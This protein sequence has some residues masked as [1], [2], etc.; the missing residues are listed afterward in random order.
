MWRER[1]ESWVVALGRV[2]QLS[3][4]EKVIKGSPTIATPSSCIRRI[5]CAIQLIPTTSTYKSRLAL[6]SALAVTKGTAVSLVTYMSTDTTPHSLRGLAHKIK[7]SHRANG[8]QEFYSWQ[9]F[10]L[11]K[12]IMDN[13]RWIKET[14]QRGRARG[15]ECIISPCGTVPLSMKDASEFAVNERCDSVVVGCRSSNSHFSIALLSTS[16]AA[17]AERLIV[18]LCVGSSDILVS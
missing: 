8:N 2:T 13:S 3:R 15:D 9:I 12:Q 10:V 11:Y 17:V 5:H 1:G 18:R 4:T 6:L 14:S 16:V 7:G